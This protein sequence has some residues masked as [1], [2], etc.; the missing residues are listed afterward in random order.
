MP[1]MPPT[2]RPK[3]LPAPEERRR[4]YDRERAQRPWRQWY[5]TARWQRIRD[6]QLTDEP[7]CRMCLAEGRVTA[8]VVCDHVEPH[9]GDPHGFWNGPFQSL[10]KPHHD[11][12]KQREDRAAIR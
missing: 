12:E 4:Q 10:C 8:A 11:S 7:L 2:F 5:Q 9:R 3:G 6:S 1:T